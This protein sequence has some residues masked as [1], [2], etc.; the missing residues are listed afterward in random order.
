LWYCDPIT[1]VWKEREKYGLKGTS[2]EWSHTTMDA[3]RAADIVDQVFLSIEEPTWVP[4][5]NF[6][7]D[8]L[9]H[10]L[11]RGIE[12]EKIKGFLKCFNAGVKEKLRAHSRTDISLNLLDQ[13][14]QS[15]S[16]HPG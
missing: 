5:Y 12:P 9:F 8:T 15:L 10:L 13:I 3:S 11:H 14:Q 1:P 2:F 4:Q 16:V 6:E 7:F